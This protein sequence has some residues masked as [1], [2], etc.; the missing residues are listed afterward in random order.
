MKTAV[1]ISNMGG[2][3]SLEAVEPYL[4]NIFN[5]PDIIDIPLPGPLRRR[6]VNWL[7]GRRGPE[8][9][10]IYR[11]IGGRSPLIDITNG[12]ADL[13]AEALNG[14]GRGQFELFP[15]MRYWHPLVEDVWARIVEGGFDRLIV[16]SLYP[17]YSTATGG[18]L[19]NLIARLNRPGDFP[20]DRLCVIDRFG[21]H[22][23]FIG[24][25]AEQIKQYLAEHSLQDR[26]VVHLLFSAHSIPVRRVKR[27]DPYLDE[28]RR[29]VETLSELLP[30]NVRTH[31]SFQSKI[32]PIKWLEPATPDK[33]D[34]LAAQGI[35]ELVVYPLGF[36]ADNSET[37]YELDIQY[38][39]HAYNSGIENFSRIPALNTDGLFVEALADVIR[40]KCG[41]AGK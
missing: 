26:E 33:I 1:M 29:A 15:A 24:A 13:L 14:S 17:F 18:S 37:L 6:F 21:T 41:G 2:P 40:E 12:Q 34:E 11:R 36:V 9:R 23:G 3:D 19:V 35:R 32:G 30:G 10:E 4:R 38:K 8:S 5:D 27:G 16:L 28:I 7:A 20:D 25:M 31:L 22:P 39:E